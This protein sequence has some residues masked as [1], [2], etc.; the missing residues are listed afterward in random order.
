M[1]KKCISVKELCAT[2]SIS[3]SFGYELANRPD[4]YPAFRV[5]DKILIRVDALEKWLEEQTS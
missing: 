1:E 4:F 3:R 2:M 5:G